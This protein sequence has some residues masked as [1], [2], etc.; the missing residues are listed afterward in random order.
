[1]TQA[2]LA[3]VP[4]SPDTGPDD[5]DLAR[6]AVD[7]YRAAKAAGQPIT[8]SEAGVRVG[9]SASWGRTAI[10]RDNERRAREE[11]DAA[12]RAAVA[13]DRA[14]RATVDRQPT[15]AAAVSAAAVATPAVRRVTTLA[16][17]VVALVAAAA[18]YDHQRQLA[19]MAGEDWRAWLLPLSVDGLIV[20]AS[21]TMLVRRRA[22]LP[23]G[24][25][26]WVSLFAGIGAS[27]GANVAAA[28]PTLVGRLVAGWPPVALL[29]AHELLLRQNRH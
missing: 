17:V 28:D 8:A 29:L 21:M 19:V 1:M 11:A 22:G 6:R 18:S 27:L 7:L 13:A 12:E 20:A 2:T 15:P 16:V 26:P 14:R 5:P 25:L 24:A 9:M 10:R 4:E 23:S 3:A